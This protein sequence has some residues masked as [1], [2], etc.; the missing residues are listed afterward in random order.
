MHM[1][2]S[3]H[4]NVDGRITVDKGADDVTAEVPDDEAPDELPDKVRDKVPNETP[5]DETPTGF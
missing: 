3:P 5:D 4:H 2:F 1:G